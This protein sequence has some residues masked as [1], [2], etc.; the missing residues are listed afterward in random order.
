VDKLVLA[1]W[2]TTKGKNE[3][4]VSTFPT[5]LT[6]SYSQDFLSLNAEFEIVQLQENYPSRIT[7]AKV[8]D[9]LLML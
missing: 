3:K 8:Q 1:S 6:N 7:I 9:N 5:K 4:E 2:I